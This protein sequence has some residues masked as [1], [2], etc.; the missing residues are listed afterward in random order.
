MSSK[1]AAS[2]RPERLR[3]QKSA[4]REWDVSLIVVEE[5]EE[6]QQGC[7][8][9]PVDSQNVQGGQKAPQNKVIFWGFGKFWNLKGELSS[10]GFV[11]ELSSGGLSGMT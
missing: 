11:R 8:L 5:Q 6:R 10:G 2:S 7:E 4:E 9:I 3:W 1:T